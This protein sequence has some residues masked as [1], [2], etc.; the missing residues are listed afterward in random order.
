MVLYLYNFSFRFSPALMAASSVLLANSVQQMGKLI[1]VL[2]YN[3]IQGKHSP[4]QN[5]SA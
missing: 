2:I 1:N 5:I 4:D 3:V